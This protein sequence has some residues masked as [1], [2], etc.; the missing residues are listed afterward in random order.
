[1]GLFKQTKKSPMDEAI[2]RAESVFDETFRKELRNHGRMYF[3]KIIHDTAKEFK[4]ELDATTTQINVELKDH[5]IKQLDTTIS[6]ITVELKDHVTK[7]LDSEFSEYSTAMKRAQDTLMESQKRNADAL[8][9][10]HERLTSTLQKSV[11]NQ[12]VMLESVFQENMTRMN[13]MKEAQE[14][15]LKTINDSVQELETQ[16]NTLN[17]ALQA[18]VAKQEEILVGAFQDNMAHV[19]EQYLLE[20]LGDQYDMKAQLPSILKQMEENK[21]AIADDMKL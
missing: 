4:Q 15:A 18:T 20:A 5:V 6:Q 11:A 16:R 2:E 10:Q 17:E 9:Q 19:V 1:M 13:S 3:E 21:Q 8:E 12:S 7:Q 14:R